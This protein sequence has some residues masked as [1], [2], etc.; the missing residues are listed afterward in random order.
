MLP[1]IRQFEFTDYQ[2][3]AALWEASDIR[4]DPLEDLERKLRRD[5]D[6]F[7]VAEHHG[8]IV[9]V[10]LGG[11][12]GRTGSINRLAIAEGQRREGLAKRLIES[13]EQRLRDRGALRCFAWIHGHNSASRSLF[14]SVGYD[15]WDDV[16]TTSKRLAES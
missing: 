4:V 11:F 2:E 15:E 9:G 13:V 8:K 7:L 16:V 1:I 5:P 6:L 10:V 3:V 12:D 14:Q